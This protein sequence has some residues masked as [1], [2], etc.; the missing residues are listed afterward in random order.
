MAE[1][2]CEARRL[3]R[4]ARPWSIRGA[5]SRAGR[6]RATRWRSRRATRGLR[7]RADE[8]KEGPAEV[9]AHDEGAGHE[10]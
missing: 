5:R 6:C 3:G 2:A 9:H 10:E 8:A 4:R 7:R 1:R